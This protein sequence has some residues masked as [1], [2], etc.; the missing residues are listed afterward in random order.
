MPRHMSFFLTTAQFTDRSKTV[1]RRIGWN[2]LKPG[3]VLMGV[4]KCQ[5][6]KKGEKVRELGLIKIISTKKEP[7]LAITDDDV[8]KEGF[9]GK[10]KDW[11]V[12]FFMQHLG[13]YAADVQVNR[14]EFEYL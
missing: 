2:F 6:L 8:A 12:A 14:I 4:Q 1:T 10:S 9:P 5:G 13:G 7:L 11:F 3:D